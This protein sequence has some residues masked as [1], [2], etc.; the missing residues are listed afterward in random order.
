M[1]GHLG[2]GLGVLINPQL[3][4]EEAVQNML[5]QPMEL[6]STVIS[7]CKDTLLPLTFASLGHAHTGRVLEPLWR[8]ACLALAEWRCR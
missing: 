3:C 4:P 8:V 1:H 6:T 2:W 7:L 5:Q